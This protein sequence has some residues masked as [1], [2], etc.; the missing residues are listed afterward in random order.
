MNF[1]MIIF[2]IKKLNIHWIIFTL[3]LLFFTDS[4]LKS[5]REQVY[6][7]HIIVI[8]IEF[9]LYLKK[10]AAMHIIVHKIAKKDDSN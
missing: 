3:V 10:L 9:I 1:G 6:D 4:Y 8:I 7:H 2:N 5:D